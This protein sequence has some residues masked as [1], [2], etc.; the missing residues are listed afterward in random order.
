MT[1]RKSGTILKY[2]VGGT[3]YTVELAC[4]VDYGNAGYYLVDEYN[5]G[6][7]YV[8]EIRQKS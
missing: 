3:T 7:A 8:I 5:D 2:T 4:E 6:M 1:V